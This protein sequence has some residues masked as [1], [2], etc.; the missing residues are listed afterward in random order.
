M[1]TAKCTV[2]DSQVQ[3]CPK[4][5]KAEGSDGYCADLCYENHTC[6]EVIGRKM[7]VDVYDVSLLKGH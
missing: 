7:L 4:A 5:M 2:C 6:I 1:L 3:C